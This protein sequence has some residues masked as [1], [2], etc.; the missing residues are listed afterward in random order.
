VT[1][2]KWSVFSNSRFLND[3]ES[4]IHS[5]GGANGESQEKAS[6]KVSSNSFSALFRDYLMSKLEALF[7]NDW[8]SISD[9]AIFWT[10]DDPKAF[11]IPDYP[12]E[13]QLFQTETVSDRSLTSQNW[14]GNCQAAVSCNCF[15][16]FG[17]TEGTCY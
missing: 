16:S 2:F 6:A 10:V 3:F 5:T 17:S 8:S 14:L 7:Q 11:A 1:R 15:H 4:S 12:M 9:Q 13:L